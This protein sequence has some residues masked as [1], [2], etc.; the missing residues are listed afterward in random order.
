[1]TSQKRL[2]NKYRRWMSTKLVPG[3][4]CIMAC[5]FPEIPLVLASRTAIHFHVSGV[6]RRG[7]TARLKLGLERGDPAAFMVLA[8]G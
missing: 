5:F 7:R 3:Q 6:S 1:M 8:R 4:R 2:P